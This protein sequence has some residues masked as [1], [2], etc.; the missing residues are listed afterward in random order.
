[1][2]ENLRELFDKKI[3]HLQEIEDYLIEITGSYDN[4]KFILAKI[5]EV[6]NIQKRIDDVINNQYEVI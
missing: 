1:M 3:H 6:V 5:Y 4:A 2:E